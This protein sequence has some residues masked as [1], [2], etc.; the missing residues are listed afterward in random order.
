MGGDG[1]G[2]VSFCMSLPTWPRMA[3][4][5]IPRCKR[6]RTRQQTP[7]TRSSVAAAGSA[8]HK[9]APHPPVPH[10]A[11]QQLPLRTLC[12]QQPATAMQALAAAAGPALRP[13]AAG[14]AQR[15]QRQRCLRVAADKGFSGGQ[16]QRLPKQVK[17]GALNS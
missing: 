13:A 10:S 3:V 6:A 2:P 16:G 7:A 8:S 1:G 17:V 12:S 11:S 4:E 9:R 5:P 15:Q 14:G